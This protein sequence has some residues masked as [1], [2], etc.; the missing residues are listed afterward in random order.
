ML[1]ILSR[2]LADSRRSAAYTT[3]AHGWGYVRQTLGGRSR[4]TRGKAQKT[5]GRYNRA[6]ECARRQ[7]QLEAGQLRYEPIRAQQGRA[8]AAGS[9]NS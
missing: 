9:V 3:T 4:S 1:D 6:Q 7:R 8:D 5:Y 2:L